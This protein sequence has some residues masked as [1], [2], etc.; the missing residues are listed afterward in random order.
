[1]V[2][3]SFTQKCSLRKFISLS[4]RSDPFH[5]TLKNVKCGSS[6]NGVCLY[7]CFKRTRNYSIRASPRGQRFI[8]I[9]HSYFNH[10]RA[11]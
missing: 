3:D 10:M 8:E 4:P 7:M 2:L 9:H 5:K 6:A 11:L 1:M